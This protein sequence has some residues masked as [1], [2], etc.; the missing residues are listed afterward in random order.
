MSSA[1]SSKSSPPQIVA[2]F[3]DGVLSQSDSDA[4]VDVV[5][6]S[7][8]QQLFSIPAGSDRDADR[9]VAS[10]RRAFESGHW[11]EAPPSFRKRVLNRFADLME[12]QGPVLDALDAEEMGKPVAEPLFNGEKAAAR[13]RF[14]AESVDKLTGDVYASDRQ[15]FVVQRWAPRGVIAAIVPWNFP[16]G[17]AAIKL[18]PALAAGNSVVLKPSEM[19]SRSA[20]R[21]ASLAL[22]AGLPPGVLNVTPGLGEIV[23]RALGLHPQVDMV[24]FT[25]SSQV[26]KLMLQYSGQSNMKVVLVECGGKSPQIVFDDGVDPEHAGDSIARFLITN[27]GQICSVGSR[28]LVQRSIEPSMLDTITRRVKQ[29]VM[30]DALDPKTTFGPIV[31]AKQCE[32]VM[33]YIEAGSAEGGELAAG[34]RRVMEQTGGYFIEPTIFRNVGA[35]ARIAQEEIFGPVLSIIPFEDESEAIRIANGTMFGLQAYVWTSSLS[36]AM[37]MAKAIR[38]PVTIN[39]DAQAGEGA[40]HAAS[41]EPAGQSGLGVEGGLAG[42]TSYLRR[43]VVWM[44]HG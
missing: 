7:T 9:A 11:S 28:L 40:G 17:N 24:T 41:W 23:G 2:P 35:N 4:T 44:N 42:M 6:P 25:G 21:L 27:Q 37:R 8:G 30:G 34:G 31:S 15:S 19:A 38:S 13:V 16:T 39:A 32:R 1:N 33:G 36:R 26:G 5:N 43:Q 3:I 10:A 29:I 22:E 20:M 18:G 12:K 14:Y